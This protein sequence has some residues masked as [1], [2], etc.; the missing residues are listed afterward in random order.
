M[1]SKPL[2]EYGVMR[3]FSQRNHNEGIPQTRD[4]RTQAGQGLTE[5]ALAFP[6]FLVVVIMVLEFG[7]LLHGYVSVVF[8][9]REGAR[10]GAVFL[11]QGDCSWTQND[12]LRESGTVCSGHQY[13]DNIRNSVARAMTVHPNPTVSITYSPTPVPPVPPSRT[14]H[15]VT[16]GVSY[17]HYWLAGI[18]SSS[19]VTL[20]STAT[21]RLEP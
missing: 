18:L 17:D 11:Y 12:L 10:A 14:G 8:A 4:I 9:A 6:I 7:F 16:V 1:L 21:A 15:L 2:T 13:T 19:P 5:F 3:V 20:S